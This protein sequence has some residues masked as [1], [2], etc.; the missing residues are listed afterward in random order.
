MPQGTSQ[1]KIIMYENR[2]PKILGRSYI[3]FHIVQM[4]QFFWQKKSSLSL[5]TIYNLALFV[6][7]RKVQIIGKII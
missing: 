1:H 5:P 7:Q 3:L 6:L 4:K 2:R